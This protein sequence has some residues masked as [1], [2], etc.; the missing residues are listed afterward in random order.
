MAVGPRE[1]GSGLNGRVAGL[2]FVGKR[3]N[4]REEVSLG[5]AKYKGKWRPQTWQVGE[6]TWSS[7]ES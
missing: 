4:L 2:P 7:G 5:C 3:E 6:G 1:T